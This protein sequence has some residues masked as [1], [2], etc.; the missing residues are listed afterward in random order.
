MNVAQLIAITLGLMATNAAA[1]LFT[2]KPAMV[3]S[4]FFGALTY[5]LLA[6]SPPSPLGFALTLRDWG[7]KWR[8]WLGLSQE[9]VTTGRDRRRAAHRSI[10]VLNLFVL[11]GLLSMCT[12]PPETAHAMQTDRSCLIGLWLGF[13]TGYLVAIGRREALDC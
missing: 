3:N 2:L 8:G 12:R 4:L 7:D 11:V 1:F 5:F 6:Q 10:A 13:M 9:A